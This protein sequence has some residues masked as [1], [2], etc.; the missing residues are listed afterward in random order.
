MPNPGNAM[1]YTSGWPKNQKRF[2]QR[3]ELPPCSVT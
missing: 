2:C 3:N 1:M